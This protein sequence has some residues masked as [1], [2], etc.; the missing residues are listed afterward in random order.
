MKGESTKSPHTS[1]R[2]GD[3]YAI[4]LKFSFYELPTARQVTGFFHNVAVCFDDRGHVP[5][6]TW[7]RHRG[8]FDAA[9]HL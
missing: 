2:A 5:E 1:V 7:Q 6:S 3:W 8:L 9:L 4:S